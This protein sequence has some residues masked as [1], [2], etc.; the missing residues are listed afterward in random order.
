MVPRA[1]KNPLKALRLSGKRERALNLG[2][3]G[4]NHLLCNLGHVISP[5]CSMVFSCTKWKKKSMLQYLEIMYK[6]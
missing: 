6:M 4:L 5:L 2:G 3:L 1:N